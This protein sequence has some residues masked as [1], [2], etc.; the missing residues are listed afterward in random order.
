[1]LIAIKKPRL[2]RKIINLKS[3]LGILMLGL[4]IPDLCS[5]ADFQATKINKRD[6]SEMV[7]VPAGEFVMGTN[8][9]YYNDEKPAHKVYLAAYYI[10][11]H[12]I[13]NAQYLKFVKATGQRIPKHSNDPQYDIWTEE[14]FP[15][16]LDDHPIFD[17]SWKDADS[18]CKWAGKRLPTEA[19]WEKA[20]RGVDERLYP[21]GNQPPESV[22][23][24]VA[25]QWEGNQ[26]YK[27]VGSMKLGSAYG[28][29]DMAGNVAEWVADWYDPE[30]YR[31]SPGKNPAGPE[32]GFYK[33]VR[34][35]SSLNVRFYLRSIDRDFD[36]TGNRAK[37]IGFRCVSS[38]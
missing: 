23:V 18:Y 1:M 16:G 4:V 26:T 10:D 8:K 6:N 30:Y 29:L 3:F 19:E 12:E 34:G 11:K 20:A 17:V 13:T 5:A 32:T 36:N 31:K 24:A 33:V 27:P 15:S 28:A 35:G 9:V 38:P 22:G 7:I 25:G 2:S 14:G 21:W 37:E